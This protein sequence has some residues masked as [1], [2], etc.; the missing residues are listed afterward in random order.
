MHSHYILIYV[1]NIDVDRPVFASCPDP[2]TLTLMEEDEVITINSS[3]GHIPDPIIAS[4][5]YKNSSMQYN[6]YLQGYCINT[7]I[8]PFGY[9]S[10]W[11]MRAH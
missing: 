11:I 4:G 7:L 8:K 9:E 3:S 10:R 5:W 2:V 6:L 1:T